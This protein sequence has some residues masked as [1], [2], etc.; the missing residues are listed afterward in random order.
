[1]G[2]IPPATEPR[3]RFTTTIGRIGYWLLQLSV[4]HACRYGDLESNERHY[5]T[6]GTNIQQR[7]RLLQIALVGPLR[8]S[9]LALL[10][11]SNSDVFNCLSDGTGQG[12]MPLSTGLID[13]A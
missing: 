2:P 12:L 13:Y 10:N 4:G 1:M 7:Y 8:L 3:W 5:C 11:N 6:H 9:Q